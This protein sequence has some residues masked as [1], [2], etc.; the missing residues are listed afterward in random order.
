M[1]RSVA[2]AL[3]LFTLIMSGGVMDSAAVRAQTTTPVDCA[4]FPKLTQEAQKRGTLVSTAIKDHADRKQICGLMTSFL[5][6]EGAVVKFLSDNETWC[7]VPPQMVKAS[8]AS[9]E[10]SSEFRTKVCSQELGANKPPSLS[11]A[12][13]IPAAD[14]A[15]NTKT[16]RGTFDTLTGNPLAR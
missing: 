12:I 13:K 14:S 15:A 5:A 1:K 6:A 8:K 16:G 9:H 2:G 4:S 3:A 7:G 10:K 11:D